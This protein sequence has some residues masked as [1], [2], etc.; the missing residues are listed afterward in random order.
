M[1]ATNPADTVLSFLERINQHEVEGLVAL[2]TEDHLFVDALGA[3]VRG[4][5]AMRTAWASYFHFFPDYI[6][7]WTEIMQKGAAVGVFGS[8][9]GT[10]CAGGAPSEENRWEI[11]A[12]WKAV[13]RDSRIAEWR[14]YCDNEPVRRIMAAKN[15]EHDK[16]RSD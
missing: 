14:V 13:V 11:P 1:S 15:P 3:R 4:R 5:E 8:A 16:K 7:S 12:A 9:R 10:Y 6:V 2:L